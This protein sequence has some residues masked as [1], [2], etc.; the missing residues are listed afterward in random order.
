MLDYGPD[1]L[2]ESEND[3]PGA[4]E[5]AA[6]KITPVL[7]APPANPRAWKITSL[8]LATGRFSGAFTLTDSRPGSTQPYKRNVVFRGILRQPPSGET[9]VGAA[10]FILKPVPGGFDSDTRSVSLL[11]N[12]P[13]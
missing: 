13:D 1:Y 8:N 7:N 5:V 2:G 12:R 11:L 6:N 10:Y 9:T 3:L 4:I